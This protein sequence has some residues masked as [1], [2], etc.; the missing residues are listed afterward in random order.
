MVGVLHLQIATQC[1]SDIEDLFH[2][3]SDLV[4]IF[5]LIILSVLRH[6]EK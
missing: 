3:T 6:Q 4:P 5:R 1:S 2:L